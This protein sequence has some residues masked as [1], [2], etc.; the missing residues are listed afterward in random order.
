MRDAVGK[1]EAEL[2]LFVS[3]TFLDK[4]TTNTEKDSISSKVKYTKPVVV[5]Q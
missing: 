4:I 3:N 5:S 2:R 1:L